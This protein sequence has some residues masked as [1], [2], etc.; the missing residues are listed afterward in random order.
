LGIL[1][2]AY[3]FYIPLQ[4]F[5][6]LVENQIDKSGFGLIGLCGFER[7][8]IYFTTRQIAFDV[9]DQSRFEAESSSL[10]GAMCDPWSMNG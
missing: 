4:R 2:T 5:Y 3:Y 10:K 8:I 6:F 7:T 9:S 1:L